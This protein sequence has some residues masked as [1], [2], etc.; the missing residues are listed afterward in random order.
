MKILTLHS[1]FIRFE[2]KKKALKD[3]EEAEKGEHEVK[4]C[5][6]VLS[7]VEKRDEANPDAVAKRYVDEV[8]DI[9]GQVKADKIVIYPYVHLTNMPSNTKTAVEVLNKA[10]AGLKKNFEVVRSPFGWYKS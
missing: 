4:E 7:S 1:D 10:E 6:V 5:L 3:D 9:A 2:A 8:E